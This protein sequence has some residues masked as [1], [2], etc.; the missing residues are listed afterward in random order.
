MMN[1]YTFVCDNPFCDGADCVPCDCCNVT[2]KC[3]NAYT[4]YADANC[5]G[6]CDTKG[7]SSGVL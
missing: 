4:D 7:D 3:P 5:C 1:D 6:V 2:Y